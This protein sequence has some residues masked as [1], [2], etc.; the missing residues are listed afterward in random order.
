MTKKN[1][2]FA[3]TLAQM[4]GEQLSYSELELLEQSGR[5]GLT[6]GCAGLSRDKAVAL[7]VFAKALGGDISAAKFISEAA[8]RARPEQRDT[9]QRFKLTL[10]V[11]RAEKSEEKR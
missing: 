4:L 8:A 2:D 1:A 10:T 5:G 9:P 7:A 11:K 6:A 3:Q